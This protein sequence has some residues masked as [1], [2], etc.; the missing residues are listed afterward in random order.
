M[1]RPTSILKKEHGIGRMYMYTKN[2]G[3]HVDAY[4]QSCI[5]G[6]L[7]VP[8]PSRPTR[9]CHETVMK[10]IMVVSRPLREIRGAA[11][12]QDTCTLSAKITTPDSLNKVRA[13]LNQAYRSVKS[14]PRICT[15]SV[16]RKA[17]KSL[18]WC[19]RAPDSQNDF[20][21]LINTMII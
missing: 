18:L 15:K 9:T 5:T 21:K 3:S 11:G 13:G 19:A 4:S 17:I 2:H 14:S 6:H 8:Q 10:P 1:C 7:E 12:Q 20:H 16:N